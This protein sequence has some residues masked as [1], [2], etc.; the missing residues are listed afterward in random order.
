MKLA[1]AVLGEAQAESL[2]KFTVTFRWIWAVRLAV[3]IRSLGFGRGWLEAQSV[4]REC[5]EGAEARKAEVTW[6]ATVA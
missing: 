2:H 3:V 1:G 5:A 4:R 6:G